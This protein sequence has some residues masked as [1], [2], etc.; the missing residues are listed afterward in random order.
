MEK[1]LDQN[2][3]YYE[4]LCYE[5]YLDIKDMQYALNHYN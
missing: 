3:D 1:F 2:Y 4:Q 5:E